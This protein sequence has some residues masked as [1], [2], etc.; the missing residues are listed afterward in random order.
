MTSP[1]T[2]PFHAS[3]GAG[4]FEA[5]YAWPLISFGV[6]SI[7][8]EPTLVGEVDP[9]KDIEVNAEQ[10]ENALSPIEVTLMGMVTEVRE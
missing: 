5:A 9:R 8:P 4:K 6:S 10:E 1:M 7:Q 3:P 2:N